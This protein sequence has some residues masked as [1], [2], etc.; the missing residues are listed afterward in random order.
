MASQKVAVSIDAG[1][2]QELDG[3]VTEGKFASRSQAIQSAVQEKLGRLRRSRLARE[4]AKLEPAE[5]QAM[6]EEGLA[7]DAAQWPEY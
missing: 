2:L 3:L 1:L 5:E 4:C 6:A 7:G